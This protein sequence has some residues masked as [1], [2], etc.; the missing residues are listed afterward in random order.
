[1]N[2]LRTLAALF[3]A[4]DEGDAATSRSAGDKAV[5]DV[6]IVAR[7]AEDVANRLQCVNM[8]QI[9]EIY[10]IIQRVCEI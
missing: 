1:V 9:T 8:T 4:Q 6:M 10:E 2:A 7:K 5:R 3:C